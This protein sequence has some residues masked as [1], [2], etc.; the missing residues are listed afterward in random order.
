MGALLVLSEAKRVRLF[1]S[2]TSSACICTR[3]LQNSADF[4]LFQ[5]FDAPDNAIA[6]VFGTELQVDNKK[7]VVSASQV[8]RIYREKDRIAI[9]W[10]TNSSAVRFLERELLGAT[11][12]E[13][14]YFLIERPPLAP[15]GFAL[16]RTCYVLTPTVPTRS[17][18]EG[19][20]ELALVQFVSEWMAAT[21][22][23]NH[24]I[25]EDILVLESVGASRIPAPQ[26]LARTLAHRSLL[27][28]RRLCASAA[29]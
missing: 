13:N 3:L 16:L 5:Y 21:I 29:K 18:A 17:L 9:V 19:S 20:L 15:E 12:Q 25:L 28:A 27:A 14:G 22:P 26:E 23:A 1:L 10:Q 11:Y 6:E 2:G 8:K 7:A 4:R 24:K